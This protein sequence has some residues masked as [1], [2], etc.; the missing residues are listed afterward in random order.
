[1]TQP[2]TDNAASGDASLAQQRYARWRQTPETRIA[3]PE[4]ATG[5][6]ER[7]GVATLF[8]VSSELPN[9]Y[10]AYT[11]DPSTPTSPEWAS[12]SGQVYTWRWVLGRLQAAAY[13]VLVRGK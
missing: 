10:H 11:G 5:L 12:P 1:M 4:E 3:G 6:I 2:H 7:V 9:L 8:P 13:L